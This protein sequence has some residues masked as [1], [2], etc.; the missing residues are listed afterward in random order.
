MMTRKRKS[1][2][3]ES[4]RAWGVFD[5][6]MYLYEKPNNN[7]KQLNKNSN[8]EENSTANNKQP[9]KKPPPTGLPEITLLSRR[10]G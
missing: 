1:K 7:N 6:H 2:K 3:P 9:L 5:V 10:L 4:R 8:Y